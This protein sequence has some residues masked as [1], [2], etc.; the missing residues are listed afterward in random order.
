MPPHSL[1]CCAHTHS[2]TFIFNVPPRT[3]TTYKYLYVPNQETQHSN[4][5]FKNELFY[6]FFFQLVSPAFRSVLIETHF[7][8]SHFV[9]FVIVPVPPVCGSCNSG[10]CIYKYAPVCE[11]RQAGKKL[12]PTW[13]RPSAD[14]GSV[15]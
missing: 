13:A 6:K 12:S 7:L 14:A 5:L 3:A 4:V 2:I 10:A 8:I 9:V 1:S 15:F 11:G